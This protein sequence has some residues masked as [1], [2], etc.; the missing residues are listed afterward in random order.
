MEKK[1]NE[2]WYQVPVAINDNYGF[3]DIGHDLNSGD[4]REWEINWD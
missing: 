3:E 1:I 2:T 4:N